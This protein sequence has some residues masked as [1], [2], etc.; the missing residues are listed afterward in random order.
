M[1][2]SH[3]SSKIFMADLTILG[4]AFCFGIGF[5]GQRAVMVDGLGPMTCNAFRFGLSTILLILALP[6]LPSDDPSTRVHDSSDEE[7]EEHGLLMTTHSTTASHSHDSHNDNDKKNTERRTGT[8]SFD[9]FLATILNYLLVADRRSDDFKDKDKYSD[10]N[11]N[12]LR[13]LI[14]P[15]A[16]VWQYIGDL[17]LFG[18]NLKQFDDL[19]T[20]SSRNTVWYW[21]IFLGC[22]NM[23]ASGFQQWGI[24]MTEASKVYVF[25]AFLSFI[26]NK[27][28]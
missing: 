21:G 16:D 17:F 5:L 18:C 23:G 15:L 12:V 28:L 14:G 10:P 13:K 2:R 9:V 25:N 19:C 27:C 7:D 6:W 26:R 24:S 4:S 3:A 22:I 20:D 11:M 1:P 8:V